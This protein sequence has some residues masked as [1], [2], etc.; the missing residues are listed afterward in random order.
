MFI[1]KIE[2]I[3]KALEGQL[4]EGNNKHFSMNDVHPYRYIAQ[5]VIF[6]VKHQYT[7]N[8]LNYKLI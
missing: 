2:D 3:N 7:C 4:I 1:L 5:L 8:L 6:T